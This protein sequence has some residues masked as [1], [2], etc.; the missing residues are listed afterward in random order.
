MNTAYATTITNK[1]I[2]GCCLLLF[3]IFCSATIGQAQTTFTVNSTGDSANENPGNGFCDTGNSVGQIGGFNISECTFRAAIQEA[4]EAGEQVEI[5]FN[6]TFLETNSWGISIIELE[7]N[8]PFIQERVTIAGETHP[9]FESDDDHPTGGYPKVFLRGANISASGIRFLS[10]G[11]GSTVRH[12]SLG[13]F[14][15]NAILLQGGSNYT[16]QN[17][18][19]GGF[20]A[21]AAV[22][23]RNLGTNGANGIAL[24]GASDTDSDITQISS[25]VIYNNQQNGIYI[26]DGTRATFIQDN[27]IG[28]RTPLEGNPFSPFAG[29]DGAGVYIA[30]DAGPDNA[31]GAFS[32]NTISN[33]ASGGVHVKADGQTIFGNK[34]GLPHDG[35]ASNYELS[36]YG[37]DSNGIILES[38]NNTVGGGGAATN[39]IA[40]S[41]EA[42]IYVE[43]SNNEIRRNLVGTNSDGEDVGQEYGILIDSGPDNEIRNSLVAN[44]RIGILVRSTGNTVVRNEVYDHELYGVQFTQGDN[45]LGSG[46]ISDAN[47]IGNNS[48]GVALTLFNA[49]GSGIS[50]QNNY[51]GTNEVGD[52]LGNETGIRLSQNWNDLDVHIGSGSGDGNIIGYNT[53][54]GIYMVI[55]FTHARIE[56]NYIG[57]DADGNPIP[58]G[59]GINLITWND[60]HPID[61]T[62]GYAAG[63]TISGEAGSAGKGNIIAHNTGYAVDFADAEDEAVN[64]AIRGNSIYANSGGINLGMDNVDVGGGSSGP[65]N[66]MNFPEFDEDETFYVENTNEIEVRYRVRTNASNADYDLGIDIFLTEEGEQQGKTFLG[67]VVYDEQDATNWVFDNIEVPSGI[68]ISSDDRIVATTT[69]SDGNTSQFSE[70]VEIGQPEPEIAV[71]EDELN[72]GSVIENETETL[73]FDIENT[74]EAELSGEVILTNDGGGVYSITGGLGNYSINPSESIQVEVEFTPDGS[75]DYS[76]DIEISHNAGNESS[77]VEVSLVGQGSEEPEPFIVVTEDELD[78]GQ[79][80]EET[81][82]RLAFEIE[83]QGDASLSGEVFLEDSEDVFEIVGLDP[84]DRALYSVDPSE[85]FEV[86]IDFTPHTVEDFTGLLEIE[87]NANNES[88]PVEVTLIGEGIKEPE[89]LITVSVDELDFNTVTEGDTHQLSFEVE[90]Q[91]SAQLSVEVALEDDGDGVFS[92]TAGEGNYNLDPSENFDVQVEFSPDTDDT[93]SGRID[94]SHN[95]DN[96]T[97]P[98][99]VT[100][101]GEGTEELMPVIAV[102]LDELDFSGVVLGGSQSLQFEIENQGSAEL[103]GEVSLDADGDGAFTIESGGGSYSLEPSISR[104]VEVTFTPDNTQDYTGEIFIS[105][106]AENLTTPVRIPLTGNGIDGDS[107]V[108]IVSDDELDFGEVPTNTMQSGSFEIE[109]DG[110]SELTG[111]VTLASNNN[112]FSI[113]EGEGGF[114]LDYSEIHTVEVAFAPESEAAYSGVIE[115][116]HNAGNEPNPVEFNL[117]GEG[118]D[119]PVPVL[120]L[121][122][123]ELDFG[124]VPLN[125]MQSVSF[126]IENEGDSELTGEVTLTEDDDAFTI[127]DGDGDFILE[128]SEIHTVEVTFAPESEAV[129]SGVIEISHNAGNEVSPVEVNLSG[130]GLDETVPVLSLSVDELDFE[131]VTEGETE[132]LTFEIENEGEAELTGA[133]FLEDSDGG[134]FAITSGEGS[135]ALA[136]SEKIEVDVT[137]NPDSDRVFSGQLNISHNAINSDDP[138]EI[139]LTGVGAEVTSAE[140]IAQKPAELILKQNYPNPFNPSTQI[141]FKL[142]KDATV[143]L[144][145]FN[146]LGQEI[147]TLVDERKSA[148]SYEVTFN[149][150]DLSSGSYIYRLETESEVMTETMTYVK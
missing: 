87:H 106:N 145:V 2:S 127:P 83:N 122:V 51:I 97:D 128:S 28:L 116:N 76:G 129:Y 80:I 101:T 131:E 84:G 112:G 13:G 141:R 126:E 117:L 71:S 62:I 90:N 48:S 77:P 125:T 148:G 43:G 25:N 49:Q 47:V 75:S 96:L 146:N 31:I 68:S 18:V 7:S 55:G 12:I 34:I 6:S 8:L 119:E 100:L 102:S 88:D 120:S 37:N 121:S 134:A 15:G 149:A 137:F 89:P 11:A 42:G 46:D 61:N 36:D 63:E 74:G 33:N 94:I 114:T 23:V 150:I 72:F 65:N 92:I 111:E 86:E 14:G 105:H 139:I 67:T 53:S 110:E 78:F 5:R 108:I 107:P 54:Q 69:D 56:G 20:W 60:A 133:I 143:L 104:Q 99:E 30:E 26:A 9:E 1:Y 93:F 98:V 103:S 22:S 17:N 79:V 81:T 40:S 21:P 16:I 10:S 57:V 85:S 29:N 50:I 109:N 82:Q 113:S 64:N 44:N 73:S 66:L 19:I 136:P 58:N 138:A 59:T 38:S 118:V 3:L 52:D 115:I 4:N 132:T 24:I 124:E 41:E 123:V 140:Q 39:T 95:A 91:G 147:A 144:R 27:I 142:P 135:L 130:E 35:V 70:A 45:T 32:G